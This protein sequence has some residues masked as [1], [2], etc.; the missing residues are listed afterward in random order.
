M[1]THHEPFPSHSRIWRHHT[2]YSSLTGASTVLQCSPSRC[3]SISSPQGGRRPRGPPLPPLPP[4]LPSSPRGARTGSG[5]E[6]LW[7][8]WRACAPGAASAAGH[9]NSQSSC[10]LSASQLFYLVSPHSVI[11]PQAS[12]NSDGTEIAAGS[13][14]DGR[15]T[16]GSGAVTCASALTRG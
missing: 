12:D 6:E 3:A 5:V 14:N 4:S 7:K 15:A 1:P 16:T 11:S 8:K 9:E 2:R 13:S 10:A